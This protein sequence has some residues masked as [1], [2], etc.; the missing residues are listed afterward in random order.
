M[1][2]THQHLADLTGTTRVTV[3]RCLGNFE[4]DGQI[5]RLRQGRIFI[6]S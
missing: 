3:T 2:M 4:R 5:V 6:Q 1:K